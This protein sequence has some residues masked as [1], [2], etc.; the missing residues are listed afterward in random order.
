MEDDRIR[1]SMCQ[2]GTIPI[3]PEES[4]TVPRPEPTPIPLP[5]SPTYTDDGLVVQLSV[6]VMSPSSYDPCITAHGCAGSSI[7]VL[8]EGVIL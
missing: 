6:A 8:P 4:A 7:R 5:K 1:R 2:V 3:R